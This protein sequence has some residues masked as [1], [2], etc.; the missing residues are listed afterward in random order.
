[1]EQEYRIPK[2]QR[3]SYTSCTIPDQA[4]LFMLR[5]EG[6]KDRCPYGTIHHCFFE[7]PFTFCGLDQAI[8]KMDEMMDELCYPQASTR[9]RNFAGCDVQREKVK[10]LYMCWETD[11]LKERGKAKLVCG[12]RVYYR[13][14][15]SWQGEILCEKYPKVFFR[16]VLELM[17]LIQS[18]LRKTEKGI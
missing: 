11:S 1:M 3:K 2:E 15:S 7:E 9:L 18:A 10:K 16:S 17:H 12:I 4:K 6:V 8:L 5:I 13:Q 14:N